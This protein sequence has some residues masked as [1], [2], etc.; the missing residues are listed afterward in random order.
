MQGRAAFS[1]QTSD[2]SDHPPRKIVCL[3]TLN[4]QTA[5]AL[6]AVRADG[7][8]ETRLMF[9]TRLM[10]V[11]FEGIRV[12]RAAPLAMQASVSK[13]PLSRD[14]ID[15]RLRKDLTTRHDRD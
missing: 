11:C 13:M 15:C 14:Q 12:G 7:P 4:A 10:R 1:R 2:G 5:S 6:S 3:A 9:E 8:E